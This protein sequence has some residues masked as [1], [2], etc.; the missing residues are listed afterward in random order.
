MVILIRFYIVKMTQQTNT[1]IKPSVKK[2]ESPN[3]KAVINNLNSIFKT[4]DITKLNKPTYNF[5]NLTSDFI[6]HYDLYGFQEYYK[7][8]RDLI[9][10]LKNSSDIKNPDYY[11][12]DCFMKEQA[13]YYISKAE[14]FK[15]IKLLIDKYESEINTFFSLQEKDEDISTIKTLMLKNKL[16]EMIV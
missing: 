9:R 4:K 3:I 10:D 2:W 12:S 16:K 7:D 1:D 15:Q 14:I 6:A 8:L 11:L 13:D 5:L